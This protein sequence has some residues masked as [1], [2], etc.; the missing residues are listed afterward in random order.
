M[1]SMARFHFPHCRIWTASGILGGKA[2]ID[3]SH[4]LLVSCSHAY[5]EA[6]HKPRP[7]EIYFSMSLRLRRMKLDVPAADHALRSDLAHCSGH[8]DTKLI[9]RARLAVVFHRHAEG[10]TDA[11]GAGEQDRLW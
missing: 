8:R 4:Q 11:A 7:R 9:A 5:T 10:A 3:S 2:A 1:D 6:R